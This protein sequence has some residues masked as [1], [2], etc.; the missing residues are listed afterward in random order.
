M[1]LKLLTG[2]ERESY[3]RILKRIVEVLTKEYV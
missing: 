2:E 1:I 3:L